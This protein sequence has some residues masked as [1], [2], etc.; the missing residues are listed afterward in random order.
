MSAP[1]PIF[2]LLLGNEPGAADATV[3]DLV[4]LNY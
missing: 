3:S 4:D 1:C 2:G